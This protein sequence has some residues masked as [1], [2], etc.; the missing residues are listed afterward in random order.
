M[1]NPKVS[2]IIPFRDALKSI[3]RSVKSILSQ[4]F[5]DIEL[6]LVND[7]STDGSKEVIEKIKDT[8]LKMV[9][10]SAG[11][12]V[13]ALNEGIYS[14]QGKYITLMDVNDIARKDRIEKQLNFLE[15]NEECDVVS[16]TVKYKMENSEKNIKRYIEWSN[17]ITSYNEIYHKRFVNSTVLHSTLMFKKDLISKYG[18]FEDGEFPEDYEM[19]LRWMNNGVKFSKINEELTDWHDDIQRLSRRHLKYNS[20]AAAKIKARYFN[21]WFTGYFNHLPDILL[22]GSKPA[23]K[24]KISRLEKEGLNIAGYINTENDESWIDDKPVFNLN[25]LPSRSFII[26]Y[27]EQFDPGNIPGLLNQK[28]LEE[29]T[30]FLIMS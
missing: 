30:N 29:G 23:T 21:Q 22:W 5:E 7:G 27:V 17:S 2:V 25:E 1:A 19:Q 10:L 9:N 6:I 16:S 4:S 26:Y 15:K 18:L 12:I 20:S 14:T 24:Q 3:E 13:V 8:R 11:G 28:G